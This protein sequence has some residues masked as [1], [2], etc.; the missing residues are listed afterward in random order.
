MCSCLARIKER[1][2]VLVIAVSLPNNKLK[3]YITK[4]LISIQ[5]DSSTTLNSFI[6]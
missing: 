2:F 6:F 5:F 4:A 1:G 3:L